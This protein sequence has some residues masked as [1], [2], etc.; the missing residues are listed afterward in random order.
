MDWRD[1]LIIV[2]VIVVVFLVLEG[3]GVIDIIPAIGLPQ[4]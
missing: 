4:G 2:L 1:I 3:F